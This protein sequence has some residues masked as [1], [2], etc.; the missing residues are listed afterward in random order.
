MV[1]D[2][3]IL[4]FRFRFLEVA[5]FLEMLNCT[6]WAQ[7]NGEEMEVTSMRERMQDRQKKSRWGFQRLCMHIKAGVGV[8]YFLDRFT[9]DAGEDVL[10]WNYARKN[11]VEE[12]EWKR[13]K[14]KKKWRKED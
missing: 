11:D 10:C 2:F 8:G 7:E 12:D 14:A 3:Y 1:Y 4:R 5:I 13:R 6:D 9:Q